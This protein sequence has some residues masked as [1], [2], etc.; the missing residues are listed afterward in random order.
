[1][2][3]LEK[4]EKVT[5][6]IGVYTDERKNI[7]QQFNDTNTITNSFW[8]FNTP[9]SCKKRLNQIQRV[10]RY[11]LNKQAEIMQDMQRKTIKKVMQ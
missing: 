9:D 5:D 6:Y 3:D 10:L 8:Y 4:L 11:L 2:N 1:M 7:R